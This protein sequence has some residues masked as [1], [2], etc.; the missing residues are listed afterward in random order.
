[1][2]KICVMKYK[3]CMWQILAAIWNVWQFFTETLWVDSQ[4]VRPTMGRKRER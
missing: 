4:R 2:L 3:V 1:M